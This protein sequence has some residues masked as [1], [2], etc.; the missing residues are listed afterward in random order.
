MVVHRLDLKEGSIVDGK[1]VVV[2]EIGKGSGL[3]ERLLRAG[4]RANL[5]RLSSTVCHESTAPVRRTK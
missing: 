5:F 4:R 2:K 1:F 3:L